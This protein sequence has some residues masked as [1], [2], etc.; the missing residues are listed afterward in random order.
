M[1]AIHTGEC[2]NCG[3]RQKLPGGLLAKH[4]YRIVWGQFEGAC[5]GSGELPFEVS[6]D[7]IERFIAR[8]QER[9]AAIQAAIVTLSQPATTPK[10][11]YHEYMPSLADG[12]KG[13]HWRE[14]TI[15]ANGRWLYFHN[16]RDKVEQ[17]TP[18]YGS[19]SDPLEAATALNTK[20]AAAFQTTIEEIEEFIAWQQRR[21][22]AW[23]PVELKPIR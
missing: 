6:C 2:Q 4:G 21:V 12:R 9:K 17:L 23:K 19:W 3:R 20:R 8:A 14:I 7:L 18:K 11:W 5:V 1:K 13:Y 16:H 10:A 15:F 22:A